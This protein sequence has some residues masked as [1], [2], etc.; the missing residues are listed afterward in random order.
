MTSETRY[1]RTGSATVNGL[2]AR[3][4]LTSQVGVTGSIQNESSYAQIGI[5]V[6]KR[7]S[8][9]TETEITSGT[10]V[11]VATWDEGIGSAIY[12]G[13]WACPQTSLAS[14]DSIVVR[15]YTAVDLPLYDTWQ[16]GQLG[17]TQLDSATWTVYYYLTYSIQWAILTFK[18][19]TATYNSRITNFSYSTPAPPP[20]VAAPV[21][22]G[23]SLSW[24][25]Y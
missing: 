14:T 10:L 7:D 8:V 9:G 17:V 6:W 12:S 18:F 4:L 24:M 16:T 22:F 2:L 5:R 15:V 23:D 25:V 13:S 11:A 3:T 21:Y 1:F 20:S 19:D